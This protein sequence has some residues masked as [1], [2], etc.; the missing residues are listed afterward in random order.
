MES[1]SRLPPAKGGLCADPEASWGHR[2]NNLLRSE[3]ELF[4]GYYL[5]ACVMMRDE[6]GP[7]IPELARRMTLSSCRH[8]PVR[9]LVPVL[10]AMPE[11]G[12][13]LGGILAGA[14]P[15]QDLHPHDRGPKG[16]HD[17]AIISNGNLH[18]PKTPRA[19]LELGPLPRSAT[20]EDAAAHD[21]RTAE[22]AP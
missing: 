3:D 18:C 13:P 1:F 10:T 4:F 21:T 5:S 2:K 11:D 15:I 22:L 19:L 14:Q 20:P 7:A 8:D 17:G 9:A 12:I 6:N 16:T